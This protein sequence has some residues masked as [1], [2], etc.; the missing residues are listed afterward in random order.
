MSCITSDMGMTPY[1]LQHSCEHRCCPESRSVGKSPARYS[2]CIFPAGVNKLALP[3]RELQISSDVKVQGLR[4][5]I[6][7][8]FQLDTLKACD[9]ENRCV[10]AVPC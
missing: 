5:N 6:L 2:C 7:S 9:T 10:W 1:R 3:N 4:A 8:W